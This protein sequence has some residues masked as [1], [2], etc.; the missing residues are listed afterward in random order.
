MNGKRKKNNRHPTLHNTTTA[1]HLHVPPP[2]TISIN[3]ITS[4]LRERLTAKT[5]CSWPSSRKQDIQRKIRRKLRYT[6]SRQVSQ[7][8]LPW[9]GC[10]GERWLSGSSSTTCAPSFYVDTFF[11][12]ASVVEVTTD[13]VDGV[14]DHGGVD[15]SR[16]LATLLVE[17]G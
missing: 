11:V 6:T 9:G 10:A 16:F 5:K 12:A 14:V 17:V 15:A 3:N 1:Y 7:P 8:I 2:T 4:S 13:E